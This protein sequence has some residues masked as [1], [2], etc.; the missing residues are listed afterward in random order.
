MRLSDAM[1][2]LLHILVSL[3]L[4][5]SGYS[6]AAAQEEPKYQR[7]MSEGRSY[8]EGSYRKDKRDEA[9]KWFRR[10]KRRCYFNKTIR[11]QAMRGIADYQLYKGDT[12]SAIK[13]LQQVIGKRIAHKIETGNAEKIRK[14][15]KEEWNRYYAA[16][17]LT[18]IYLAKKEFAKSRLF[19]GYVD[20]TVH[21]TWTCGIGS[22]GHDMFVEENMLRY[23]VGTGRP[24]DAYAWYY[25]HFGLLNPL[26][27]DLEH[28]EAWDKLSTN[29]MIL[30]TPR[31]FSVRASQSDSLI[32]RALLATYSNEKLRAAFDTMAQHIHTLDTITAAGT[33]VRI[34][35]GHFFGRQIRLNACFAAENGTPVTPEQDERYRREAAALIQ[36][37]WIYRELNK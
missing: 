33:K 16:C 18:T 19:L 36:Q 6:T 9:I 31:F 37:S 28:A 8:L 11:G 21:V 10:V 29:N 5:T 12:A 15:N 17:D 26:S 2:N 24:E 32:C 20:S 7:W 34:Y 23:L 30:R 13:T 25:G 27:A 14:R 4:L 35:Y 1:R 22:M 3:L